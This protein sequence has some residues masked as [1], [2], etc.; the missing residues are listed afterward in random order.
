MIPGTELT[1][2][3]EYG[4]F[5]GPALYERASAKLPIIEHFLYERDAICI[6]ADPGV[7]KS[8]LALQVLCSLTTGD[9]FLDT[10]SVA[11]KCKVLYVQTE[12]D[13]SETI[14]RVE[15]MKMGLRLDDS[16]WVH[17]N[18]EGLNINTE[19]G[20]RK[21]MQ[22]AKAPG[23]RYDV[24]IFDPLYTTVKGSM[25]LDDVATDW[26]R[27]IRAIKGAFNCAMIILHH[28]NKEQ[29]LANGKRLE[30]KKGNVFGSVF[31][32]AFFSYTYKLV[33][34]GKT[35]CLETGKERNAK[36]FDKIYLKMLEPK[37]LM[38]TMLDDGA[39]VSMVQ[40][41]KLLKEATK[42]H[43]AAEIIK[44]TELSK[45]TIHRILKTLLRNGMVVRGNDAT[46]T[47]KRA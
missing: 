21:F 40:V 18:I 10:Y 45:A 8:I 24:I 2:N 26:V 47:W 19:D 42:P 15:A 31:W 4:V 13:R 28:D 3:Q 44:A 33:R 16:N 41:E 22:L 29:I 1:E 23:M 35:Y 39:G 6:S 7:G 11:R 25:L 46:Y 5:W 34:D 30:R 17:M 36:V 20:L 38:F 43:T 37:P 9:D 14:E 27:N 12:G 32:G